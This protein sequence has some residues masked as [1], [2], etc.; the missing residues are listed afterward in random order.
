MAQKTNRLYIFALVA[1]LLTACEN[2][3]GNYDASGTF[4]ATEVVV[5]S[6]A[7]GQIMEMH[8]AEGQSVDANRPG[9]YIDTIPLHLKKKQLLANMKAVDSKSYNVALQIASV[10]QQITKQET[11]LARFKNL[12]KSNAANQKQVDDIQSAIDLLQRQLAAVL[13]RCANV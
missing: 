9:G 10:K 13:E 3:K 6:Q 12:V 5:S 2:K 4:E 1:L 11:E 8:I 7:S